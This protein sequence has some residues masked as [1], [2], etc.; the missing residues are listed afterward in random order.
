MPS[1]SW[2]TKA[3]DDALF[4]RYIARLDEWR[5]HLARGEVSYA[6]ARTQS[7]HVVELMRRVEGRIDAETHALLTDAL[8][9]WA[10]LQAMEMTLALEA[11]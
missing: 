11:A 10:L 3:G 8:V 1:S 9:E 7:E 6:E 4:E 2:F 5:E